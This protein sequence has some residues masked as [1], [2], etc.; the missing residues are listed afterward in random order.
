MYA[1]STGAVHNLA[2]RRGQGADQGA[3]PRA[4]PSKLHLEL[5]PLDQ[6]VEVHDHYGQLVANHVR[7]LLENDCPILLYND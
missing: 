7:T 3:I 6:V 1:Q 4:S 5:Q 2:L